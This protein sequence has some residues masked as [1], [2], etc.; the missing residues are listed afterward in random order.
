MD[1]RRNVLHSQGK[2]VYFIDGQS[3]TNS[4]N[5]RDGLKKAEDYAYAHMLNTKDIIKFDSIMESKYY[6]LLKKLEKEGKIKDIEIHKNFLLIPEFTNAN[7]EFHD[8][9][10]YE[11]DFCYYDLRLHAY[12]VVDVKGFKEDV[13]I[14]KWKQFDYLFK[15][16]GLYLKVVQLKGGRNIDYLN[17]ENWI[18]L[19]D[20]VAPK[21]R[22]KK[23][24]EE[25][26]ELK[27]KQKEKEKEERVI[28]RLKARRE[29]L[30]SLN[31]L[32]R[33]QAKRLKEINDV[34]KEKGLLL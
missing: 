33:A 6:M 30:L 12:A 31:K 28:L 3:F 4:S 18:N 24:K 22:T 1:Y 13:F 7:G 26:E 20:Y 14:I 16:K 23:M 19:K 2:K 11:A 10:I 21:K 9:E 25:I 27:L 5:K 8:K 15:E 17:E 32:T 29:E 34:L